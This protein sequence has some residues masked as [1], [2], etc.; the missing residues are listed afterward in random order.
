MT[1]FFRYTLVAI[2]CKCKCGT[3]LV[4]KDNDEKSLKMAEKVCNRFLLIEK[5]ETISVRCRDNLGHIFSNQYYRYID[6]YM[7]K[8]QTGS[9]SNCQFICYFYSSFCWLCCLLNSKN[10]VKNTLFLGSKTS[11]QSRWEIVCLCISN[12][13]CPRQSSVLGL[14]HK[15]TF[16]LTFFILFSVLYKLSFSFPNT[17]LLDCVVTE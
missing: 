16:C 10:K 12:N 2:W 17:F 15:H 11:E 7:Y 8:G 6:A 13:S 14:L 9:G 4:Q 5:C 3:P 1:T